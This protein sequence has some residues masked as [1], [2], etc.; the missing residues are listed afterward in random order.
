MPDNPALKLSTALAAS[1]LFGMPVWSAMNAGLMQQWLPPEGCD[2]VAI[3][4]DNDESATGQAAAY[5]LA[6]TLHAK[7]IAATVHVPATV[8]TD[9]NDEL[10]AG[11]SSE[12]TA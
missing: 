12:A 10:I 9:W 4:A 7:R 8:G 2:E 6:K 1:R 3:F 5:A 11:L